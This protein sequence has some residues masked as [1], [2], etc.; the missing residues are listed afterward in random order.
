MRLSGI[1]CG[2][3]VS[4]QFAL[5]SEAALEGKWATGCLKADKSTQSEVMTMNGNNLDVIVQGFSD[6]GC[7]TRFMTA[8]LTGTF[9]MGP[10][11]QMVKDAKESELIYSTL[12]LTFHSSEIVGYLITLNV[13]GYSDWQVDQPKNV[14]GQTCDKTVMPKAGDTRYNLITLPMNN[15]LFLG[16]ET[17]EFDGSTP[18]KRP[19]ELDMDRPFNKQ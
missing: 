11:S 19:R 15:R 4:A 12:T 10:D 8:N 13:C 7:A 9:K 5:G 6:Q 18:D 14:L 17:K 2:L 1:V 3:L 16:K